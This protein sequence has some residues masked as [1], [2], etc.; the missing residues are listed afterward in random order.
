MYVNPLVLALWVVLSCVW[1]ELASWRPDPTQGVLGYLKPVPAFGTLS[2]V[3]MFAI[4]WCVCLNYLA[5]RAV[6]T[7]A[8]LSLRLNRWGFEERSLHVLRRPDLVDMPAYYSRSPASGFWI[9]EYG[10]R[11]VGFIALDASLDADSDA[12][13]AP[14][15]AGPSKR[16]AAK[17]GG[18]KAA[19]VATSK[20]TAPVATIRHFYVDEPYRPAGMADDLLAFALGHAF[21]ADQRLEAVR[22]HANPLYA[23]VGQSLAKHGFVLEKKLDRVGALRWQNTAHILQKDAWVAQKS[24]Q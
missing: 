6:P 11:F 3:F 4:D 16:V 19:A 18:R 23:Y 20:G 5:L 1:V 17:D 9:L 15:P 7:R 22:A 12:A 8:P 24:R 10:D 13:V 2:I 21:G 14:A